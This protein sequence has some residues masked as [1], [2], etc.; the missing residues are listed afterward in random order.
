MNLFVTIG[1][2]P[3]DPLIIAVDQIFSSTEYSVTCQ[4]I[5]NCYK[6][7][8]HSYVYFSREKYRELIANA[9]IVITHGGAGTVYELLEAGKKIVLVPNLSRIDKHQEEMAQFIENNQY[10]IVCRNMKNLRECVEICYQMTFR[11]YEK[12]PFFMAEDIIKFFGISTS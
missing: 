7:K 12:T 4:I 10:G 5:A 9:E 2:T 3:F 1:T 6:P 11:N 8:S